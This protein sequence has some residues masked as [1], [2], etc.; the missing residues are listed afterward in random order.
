MEKKSRKIKKILSFKTYNVAVSCITCENKYEITTT[1]KKEFKIDSCSK[2]HPFYLGTQKFESKAGRME[3]FRQLEK[4][5]AKIQKEI[6]DKIKVES[7]KNK[8][9]DKK[10][11]KINKKEEE[12]NNV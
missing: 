3:R 12:K 5:T 11:V 7:S 10:I 1:L 4:K 6:K 8:I 2:C 9:V